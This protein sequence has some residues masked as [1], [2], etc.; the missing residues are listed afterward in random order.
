VKLPQDQIERIAELGYTE[1]E[2]RF[3]YIV[4][5]H[6]GYFTL[7]QFNTFAGISSGQ[8]GTTFGQKLL[9]RAHATVR[10][11]LARGSIFHLF[12]QQVYGRIEKGN[13]SHLR[14]HSFEHIRTRLVQLDFLLQNSAHDFL[15]TEEEKINLFCES[16]AVPKHLLPRKVYEIG[17]DHH[18]VVR[19]FADKFPLFLAAPIEGTAPVVTFGYVDSGTGS[20]R[21]F[22]TY[23][24]AYQ[25]LFRHLSS[26]R[27]LY[28]ASRSTEFRRAGER[29][30]ASVSQP[31]EPGP[32]AELLRYFDIRRKWERHEYLVPIARD[33]EFLN[34]AR[35]RFHGE[36]F[37]TLYA[38]W[39]RG[40]IAGSELRQEVPELS[41]QQTVFF[42]TCLV[43]NGRS[44][45]EERIRNHEAVQRTEVSG[46]ES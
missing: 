39:L 13:V 2:A 43:R 16:L 4:A 24:G 34:S 45:L 37:E 31:F 7:G 20:R 10:D 44:A 35:R 33:L 22:L 11:Y 15:E 41:R 40:T 36:H 23:L 38:D 27:L 1:A 46:S 25:G 19:Y 30:R 17:R 5:T 32:S 26:F 42:D 21:A 8:R 9:K 14:R 12:S 3:L 29:F 28:I 18:L 6:S